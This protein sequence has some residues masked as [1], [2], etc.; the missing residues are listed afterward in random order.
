MGACVV[1]H[2]NT[3]QSISSTSTPAHWVIVSCDDIL[4]LGVI[5]KSTQNEKGVFPLMVCPVPYT[6]IA[7]TST[8]DWDCQKTKTLGEVRQ[9][10]SSQNKSILKIQVD[11]T[12]HSLNLE[13][14]CDVYAIT[15]QHPSMNPQPCKKTIVAPGVGTTL[16]I[17]GG[18]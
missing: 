3:G 10:I 9:E 14:A 17:T 8:V 15:M 2:Q 1:L 16:V 7:V 18:L 4:E 6:T 12:L 11:T 5:S 13:N